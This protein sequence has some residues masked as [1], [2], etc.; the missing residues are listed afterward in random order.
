MAEEETWELLV[1]ALPKMGTKDPPPDFEA[2][3]AD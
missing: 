2:S 1:T 3:F